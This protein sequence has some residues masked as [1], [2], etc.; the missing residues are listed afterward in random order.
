[1]NT[2]NVKSEEEL[3]VNQWHNVLA[4]G[5]EHNA[6]QKNNVRQDQNTAGFEVMP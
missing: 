6:E 3:A 4:F 1:M 2:Y 5:A